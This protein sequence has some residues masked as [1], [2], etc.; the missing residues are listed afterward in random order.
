M[1]SSL[2]ICNLILL[3]IDYNSS[4]L[5][6]LVITGYYWWVIRA[7]KWARES[8]GEGRVATSNSKLF[9]KVEVYINATLV[10]SLMCSL[11]L[12]TK[13]I[14]WIE[15]PSMQLAILLIVLISALQHL[16]TSGREPRMTHIGWGRVVQTSI[17]M[18]LVEVI[19]SRRRMVTFKME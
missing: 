7:D 10:R 9:R 8:W 13:A 18:K 1:Y 5:R 12:A 3:C 4:V 11:V 19:W 17:N 2:S 16:E 15:Q 14:I 6:L